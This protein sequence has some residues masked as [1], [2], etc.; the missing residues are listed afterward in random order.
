MIRLTQRI[1]V[2]FQATIRMNT[3]ENQR[4]ELENCSQPT[5]WLVKDALNNFS[6]IHE[7]TVFPGS[8]NPPTEAHR[9]MVNLCL[10]VNKNLLLLIDTVN[11]DKAFFGA[12]L[13]QRFDMLDPRQC[14]QRTAGV[15]GDA[16]NLGGWRQ[17]RCS[18]D[19]P[20]RFTAITFLAQKSSNHPSDRAGWISRGANC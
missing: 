2:N 11:A 6:S 13:S 19:Q 4:A 1:R 9:M 16:G 7:I 15:A 14:F 18:F 3:F 17:Q 8:F 5:L 10:E 20:G 12:S